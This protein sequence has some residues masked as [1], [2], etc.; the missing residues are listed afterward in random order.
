MRHLKMF[1]KQIKGQLLLWAQYCIFTQIDDTGICFHIKARKLMAVAY[2]G[3]QISLCRQKHFFARI[4][5]IISEALEPFEADIIV[6][7]FKCDSGHRPRVLN[8]FL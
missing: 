1:L 4:S 6:S 2:H 3:L 5:K 8:N 7:L